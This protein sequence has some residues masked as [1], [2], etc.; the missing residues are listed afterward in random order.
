MTIR[1]QLIILVLVPLLCGL[2]AV[3]GTVYL[4]RITLL[5]AKDTTQTAPLTSELN[6]FIQFLQEPAPSSGKPA[7]YHLQAARNRISSLTVDLIPFHS[8]VDELKLLKQLHDG[9]QRLTKQLDQLTRGNSSLSSRGA[10]LLAQEIKGFFPIIDQLHSYYSRTLQTRNQQINS[11]N[12][13]LL[14]TATVWPLLFSLV[15]YRTL[16]RPL[17]QLKDAVA[18]LTRGELSY[19]LTCQSSTELGRLA[20]AFN[21]MTETRQRAENT[22]KDTES[23][24]KDIFDN[25]HMI[26]VC[27]E[28]NGAINYCNDYLLQVTGYRRHEL[29]GKNWFDLF[30]PEPEPVKQVFNQMVTKGEIVHHFQNAI[31]TKSGVLRMIAWNNTLTHDSL[32]GISGVTSI[33]SDITDHYSAEKALEQS[34]QMLRALVDGNPESL[35]LVDRNATIL[36]ANTT[37]ARRL[38]KELHQIIGS[39]L[40]ELFSPDV[41]KGRREIGRASCRE[42]V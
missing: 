20:T 2:T 25:L 16:A 35:Y 5:T 14:L 4:Q 40:S 38:S 15:L 1:T 24:L 29:I 42:R 19:R 9:P 13:I 7:K 6:D 33:G 12:R 36:I 11:L 26:T 21:K 22:A 34:Q 37:F 17:S 27:L 41:A 8:T 30:I 10:A 18:A 23:R 31:L 32:G 28:T 39:T 3:G